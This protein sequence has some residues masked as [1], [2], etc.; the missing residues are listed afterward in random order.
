MKGERIDH[1]VLEKGQLI[2]IEDLPH[3]FGDAVV[4]AI[5]LRELGDYG[6]QYKPTDSDE[7]YIAGHSA[8]ES[9]G[10]RVYAH[11]PQDDLETKPI[12]SDGGSSSYYDMPLPDWLV[13]NIK[14]RQEAG[15]AYI[16]TEEL[17]DVLFGNDFNFGTCFKSMVRAY[18]ATLG[19]GKAGNDLKYETNKMHYYTNKILEKGERDAAN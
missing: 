11:K 19:A 5:Y 3:H 1:K 7:V 17:I 10:I 14:A 4:V 8:L 15:Q 16:K 12:K 6:F 13:E 18:G 9:G 2:Y